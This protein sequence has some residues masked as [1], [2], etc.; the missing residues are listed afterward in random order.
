MKFVLGVIQQLR[1]HTLSIFD[2]PS[3]LCRQLQTILGMFT[4]YKSI[5]RRHLIEHLPLLAY[6][7]FECFHIYYRPK[8]L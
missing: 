2:H 3:I 8:Y 6:V 7:F 4:V 1:G 5:P